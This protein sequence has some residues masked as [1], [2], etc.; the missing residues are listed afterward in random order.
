MA[1]ILITGG[2]GL[3]GSALS[4]VL[5]AKGHRVHHLGRTVRQVDGIHTYRWD[6]RSGFVDPAC[7]E[8]VSHIVHLAGAGIA[9]RPWTDRRVDELIE[10]RTGSAHLLL[11]TVQAKKHPITAFVSAAGINYYG[12]ITT[13]HVFTETDAPGTDT[14]ARISTAWETAVDEWIPLTRVVK[15]RTPIV[16]AQHGGAFP[17]LAMPVKFGLGAALGSGDQWMPWVH[18]DDLVRIYERVLFNSTMSGA[19]NVN[20]TDTVTNKVFLKTLAKAMGRPFFLPNVPGFLLRIALVEM[21]ELLLRGSRAS[22]A[23][24]LGAEFQFQ[25]PELGPA[26]ENLMGT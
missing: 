2:S 6:L 24:L 9:D 5:L 16:L 26:L 18:L 11:R 23:R 4:K 7:L 19:Y 22:N 8:S 14:I 25:Y 13:D 15:L 10:S 17:K 20:T 12:A 21:A 3:I 1:T